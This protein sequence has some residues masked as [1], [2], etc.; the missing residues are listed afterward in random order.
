MKKILPL[1]I[2][3][4]VLTLTT[5][6][7]LNIYG[8]AIPQSATVSGTVTRTIIIGQQQYDEGWGNKELIVYWARYDG[9]TLVDY[10]NCL[11]TY[12]LTDANGDFS[13]QC[14][15]DSRDN[16]THILIIPLNITA[17]SWTPT[18]RRVAAVNFGNYDFQD[19][20]ATP[21]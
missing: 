11:T 20:H 6:L 3:N 16:A 13:G 10:G 12:L 15:W 4:I 1:K 19:F 8:F 21:N 7:A 18:S 9:E 5:L 14:Y 2:K 17:Y